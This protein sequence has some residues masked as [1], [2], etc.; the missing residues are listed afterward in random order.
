MPRGLPYALLAAVCIAWLAMVARANLDLTSGRH[1]LHMDEIVVHDETSKILHAASPKELRTALRGEDHRYGRTLWYIAAAAAVFPEMLFGEPAQI[2][3]TRMVL[4]FCVLATCL[5]CVFAWIGNPA[6][7]PAAL[8]AL[9]TVP[10]T[11]YFATVPKPEPVQVLLLAIFLW[12]FLQKAQTT[13]RSWIFYGAAFGT[14]INAIVLLPVLLTVGWLR[15]R[16]LVGPKLGALVGS[17]AWFALGFAISVPVVLNGQRGI[18][19][20]L[21]WTF[22]NTAHGADDPSVGPISWGGY[23]AANLVSGSTLLSVACLTVLLVM[24]LVC[25]VA[26]PRLMLRDPLFALYVC[27]LVLLVSIVAGVQRLWGHYLYPGLFLLNLATFVAFERSRARGVGIRLAAFIGL[28][29]LIIG[30]VFNATRELSEF[31]R[32]SK[33]TKQA[34]YIARQAEY[35]QFMRALDKLGSES[36][37]TLNVAISPH[38]F[39]PANSARWIVTPFWGPFLRW[40]EGY[41][42]ILMYKDETPESTEPPSVNSTVQRD[43]QR[44]R[45]LFVGHTAPTCTAEPCYDVQILDSGV[46]LLVKRHR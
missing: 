22:L 45:A 12:L 44:S 13:G 1:A 4:A 7:R 18:R 20:Y 5:I 14:K 26:K 31:D 41:D 10:S 28:A 43:R 21:G 34:E 11:S 16:A 37:A 25:F 3:A 39:R 9:L 17:V 27:G 15:H 8:L 46:R 6:L 32:M 38:M 33:R 40:S 36:G 42:V 24:P 30:S 29:L 19:S 35:E 23:I 2:V